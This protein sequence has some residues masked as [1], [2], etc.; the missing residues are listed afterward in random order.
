MVR[1]SGI[2]SS[3][4]NRENKEIQNSKPKDVS[5]WGIKE[6]SQNQQMLKKPEQLTDNGLNN[7]LT[8]NIYSVLDKLGCKCEYGKVDTS[9]IT[10]EKI[11]EIFPE[12]QFYV[13]FSGTET[14]IFDR[15]NNEPVFSISN[16]NDKI[17]LFDY[18]N[19]E[20]MRLS[21]GIIDRE[22]KTNDDNSSEVI[23]FDNR[24]NVILKSVYDSDDNLVSRDNF[25]AQEIIDN[26]KTNNLAKNIKTAT[27]KG[28]LPELLADYYKLTGK[29]LI[30][31]LKDEPSIQKLITGTS[32]FRR[33]EGYIEYIAGTL[34]EVVKKGN[35]DEVKKYISFFDKAPAAKIIQKFSENGENIISNIN[36]N[37][38]ISKSFKADLIRKIINS[39]DIATSAEY[40]DDTFFETIAKS[41]FSSLFEN[42][43]YYTDDIKKDF[44]N[45]IKSEAYEKCY[46]DIKRL[47][48]RKINNPYAEI[49]EINGKY[50][51]NT[52][53][54]NVGNCWL[55]ASL[56]SINSK[57]KTVLSNLLQ[58]NTPEKGYITVSLKGVGE[59]YVISYDE[60]NKSNYLSVGD[61]DVR[62]FEIAID[63]YIRD[64]A[65]DDPLSAD[66]LDSNANHSE[67]LYQ[68]LLGN[69]ERKEYEN[70]EFNFNDKKKVFSFGHLKE[71]TTGIHAKN[72]YGEVFDIPKNHAISITGEDENYIYIVN[73]WYP[74]NKLK[75]TREDFEKLEP[76]ISYAE[77]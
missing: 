23:N 41:D 29:D 33:D 46:V 24:H 51:V 36:G 3:F 27:D 9:N 58:P 68:V 43:D 19:H 40:M 62:A 4:F 45:N 28:L 1:I 57:D 34:N 25:L 13:E 54:G 44:E 71:D 65:Y 39:I 11:K 70:N 26:N 53:Q 69:G 21:N 64:C 5:I 12:N 14:L 75:I 32:F 72:Q 37:E 22:G 60:I 47:C 15:K 7:R 63:R 73:P 61:G 6:P 16:Y 20:N 52:N 49:S 67:F 74:T 50:D 18:K 8:T 59:K 76:D 56:I 42:E 55:L 10:P 31:E 77:L 38:N 35:Y 48:N 30:S 17:T 66:E 2:F